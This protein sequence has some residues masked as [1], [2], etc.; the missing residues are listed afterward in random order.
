VFSSWCCKQ[1]F[2]FL[3]NHFIIPSFKRQTLNFI[4]VYFHAFLCSVY[5]AI[6]RGMIMLYLIKNG[7][8]S[9]LQPA[10]KYVF[11]YF[12]HFLI[13]NYM[14]LTEF[15]FRACHINSWVSLCMKYLFIIL[16]SLEQQTSVSYFPIVINSC[17]PPTHLFLLY[18]NPERH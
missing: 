10:D 5:F 14:S 15:E 12:C 4:V 9:N 11:H 7:L 18:S 13:S 16:N 2:I 8:Y 6:L 1:S 3:Y 17:P